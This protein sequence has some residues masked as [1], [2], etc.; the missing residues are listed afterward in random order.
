MNLL[1]SYPVK[2]VDPGAYCSVA[3]AISEFINFSD[4]VKTIEISDTKII[5]RKN[6][7]SK[8]EIAL[9][10]NNL[11]YKDGVIYRISQEA[12][13]I[14]DITKASWIMSALRSLKPGYMAQLPL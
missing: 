13:S 11:F 7:F 5:F 12:P 3:N 4:G 14:K 9:N 6:I 8:T 2:S 1:F 10:V